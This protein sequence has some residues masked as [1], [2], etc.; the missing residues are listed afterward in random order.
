N[1]C[2]W[3][4]SAP[5]NGSRLSCGRLARQRKGAG[6]QSVPRQGHNTPLPLKRSPPVSFKRLLGGD[7]S[8]C[9][10]VR[11]ASVAVALGPRNPSRAPAHDRPASSGVGQPPERLAVLRADRRFAQFDLPGAGEG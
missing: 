5:P 11:A 8:C 7:L 6:R 3:G 9:P 1:K 4:G 10:A 2:W